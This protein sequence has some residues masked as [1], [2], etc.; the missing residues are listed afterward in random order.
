MDGSES[1]QKNL[2]AKG[3]MAG[4]SSRSQRPGRWGGSDCLVR[5]VTLFAA[6]SYRGGQNL[7]DCQ[8]RLLKI[9]P[10][11]PASPVAIRPRVPGSGVVTTYC[12]LEKK[13]LARS[14]FPAGNS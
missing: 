3:Q 12:P 1:N 8:P 9:S 10:T 5:M 7:T 14:P 13:Y 2:G 6:W 11:M 4:T